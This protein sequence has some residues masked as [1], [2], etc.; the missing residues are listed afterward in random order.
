MRRWWEE[1]ASS[2]SEDSKSEAAT[3]LL[4]LATSNGGVER[5]AREATSTPHHLSSLLPLPL[6]RRQPRPPPYP[7]LQPYRGLPPHRHPPTLS[8]PSS[9]PLKGDYTGTQTLLGRVLA[10]SRLI[11]FGNP[12]VP[13]A[14]SHSSLNFSCWMPR[15]PLRPLCGTPS[16]PRY[17][18]ALQV[19]QV[20]AVRLEGALGQRR[21]GVDGEPV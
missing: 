21:G 9:A 4:H 19:G 2:S 13:R 8:S 3:P 6:Q 17:Y 18:A 5:A 20:V 1:R 10:K 11:H 7:T 16:V 14:H 12:S 15:P